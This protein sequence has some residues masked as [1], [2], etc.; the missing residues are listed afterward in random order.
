MHNNL[1]G[2]ELEKVPWSLYECDCNNDHDLS[3]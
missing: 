2:L 3:R 1:V